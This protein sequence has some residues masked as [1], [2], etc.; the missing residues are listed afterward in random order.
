ML[1]A[2]YL[3]PSMGVNREGEMVLGPHPALPRPH[4]HKGGREERIGPCAWL[5]RTME[6]FSWARNHLAQAGHSSPS[7]GETFSR[8]GEACTNWDCLLC[9]RLG[10]EPP[11]A[12]WHS[13]TLQDWAS[14]R[15]KS[16][17]LL[18]RKFPGGYNDQSVP[19]SVIVICVLALNLN[20]LEL[21]LSS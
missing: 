19:S 5:T 17:P 3:S 15:R 11:S 7:P 8:K 4:R 18:T 9:T 6:P 2:W 16:R 21:N 10:Q 14:Q 20:R 1:V 12:G 13:C